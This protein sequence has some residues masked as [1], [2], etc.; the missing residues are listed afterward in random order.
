[1]FRYIRKHHLFASFTSYS[2]QNIRT[3][4]H[5]N[6]RFDAK[7]N[8][9]WRKYLLQKKFSPHI[10][11]YWRI[12]ALKY[13]F[14]SESLQDFRKFHIQANICLKIFATFNYTPFLFFSWQIENLPMSASRWWWIEPTYFDDS[15]NKGIVF[16]LLFL[17]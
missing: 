13:S 10:F 17:F 14:W 4:S 3:N 2:L 12:F 1:M 9:C 16:F 15:S 6:I 5:T 11:S 8:T 7:T